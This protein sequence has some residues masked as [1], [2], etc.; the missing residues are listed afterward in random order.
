VHAAHQALKH[1]HTLTTLEGH[2]HEL[3]RARHYRAIAAVLPQMS[4]VLE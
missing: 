3:T 1:L 2:L 4:Q